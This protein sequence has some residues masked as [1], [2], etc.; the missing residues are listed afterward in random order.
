MLGRSVHARA[1]NAYA[2]PPGVAIAL[3]E[4]LRR[5]LMPVARALGNALQCRNRTAT[6]FL[7][8]SPAGALICA[9][10]RRGERREECPFVGPVAHI[11][12]P[13]SAAPAP[14]FAPKTAAPALQ[15]S[16]SAAGAENRGGQG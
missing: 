1:L 7:L 5:S 4:I 13:S 15:L 14:F 8:P 3:S 12:S 9:S 10:G 16:W 2:K 6:R 11:P